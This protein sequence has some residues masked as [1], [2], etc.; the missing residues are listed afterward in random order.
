HRI[1]RDIALR[2]RKIVFV[3][4]HGAESALPEMPRALAPALDDS[5]IG[6]MHPRQRPAQA[7]PV[8]WH[9]N[10]MDVVRHQAPGPDLD[11][12]RLAL[13]GEQVAIERIIVVAEERP[14][15]AVAA[16]GDEVRVTG[17][18]DTGEA[19]HERPWQRSRSASI[20]C[21]VTALSRLAHASFEIG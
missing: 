17:N 9:Q 7:V 14:G 1:E 5:G 2:R 19:G 12:S 20:E 8:G 21:T 4:R 6:A 11:R 13:G 16:L 10:E 18:D 3:H 15:A